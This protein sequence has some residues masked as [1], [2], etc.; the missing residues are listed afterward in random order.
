[1]YTWGS[2]G[3]FQGCF[4]ADC[5]F[6]PDFL[7]LLSEVVTLKPADCVILGYVLKMRISRDVL[8]KFQKRSV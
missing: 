1:M 6:K 3:C 8:N 5:Y 7:F 2:G 4:Q